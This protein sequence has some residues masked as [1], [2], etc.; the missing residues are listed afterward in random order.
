MISQKNRE[1]YPM[2]GEYKQVDSFEDA[3]YTVWDKW[4]YEIIHYEA[5]A[6][7]GSHTFYSAYTKAVVIDRGNEHVYEEEWLGETAHSDRDRWVNDMI[8]KIKYGTRR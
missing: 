6:K 3:H 8:N 7:Y 4:D 5:D 2:I 1:M